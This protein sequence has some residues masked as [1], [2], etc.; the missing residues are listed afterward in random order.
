[1]ECDLQVPPG[2]VLRQLHQHPAQQ[3]AGETQLLVMVVNL[4]LKG[5]LLSVYSE[6]AHWSSLSSA[7]R[8]LASCQAL[9]CDSSTSILH[10]N[11]QLKP[12]CW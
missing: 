5:C 4:P 2:A 6:G 1:M 11:R 3:Q 12:S 10:S 9:Y 8:L 7:H